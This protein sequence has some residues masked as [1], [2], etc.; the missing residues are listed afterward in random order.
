MVDQEITLH[1]YWNGIE[2]YM[3]PP[4]NR[5]RGC[6]LHEPLQ[7]S[8][9]RAAIDRIEPG[10]TYVNAGACYGYYAIMAAK[11]RVDIVIVA[12]EKCRKRVALLCKNLVHA[13]TSP[14][15]TV[16]QRKATPKSDCDC[17]LLS[18]DIDGGEV[19]FFRA[20]WPHDDPGQ[21][22]IST[23]RRHHGLLRS[24]IL[25]RGYAI[26]FAARPGRITRQRDGLIWATK[27]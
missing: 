11:L 17:D 10:G 18:M 14:F 4:G 19:G 20:D 12:V 15:V 5:Y 13:K 22:L 27:R 7:E 24:L 2:L 1:R 25:R 6:N 9:F 8:I 21:L 3:P 16:E 26:E 23:H